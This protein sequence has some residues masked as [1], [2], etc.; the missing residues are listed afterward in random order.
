MR[1]TGG[2][3]RLRSVVSIETIVQGHN[4]MVQKATN[5]DMTRPVDVFK[6]FPK[7]IYAGRSHYT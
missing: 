6:K 1:L 4:G 7:H 3:I 2:R 5:V